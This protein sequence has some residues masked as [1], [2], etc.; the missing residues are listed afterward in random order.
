MYI[1]ILSISASSLW[2]KLASSG[3][4]LRSYCQPD[5]WWSLAHSVS[6]VQDCPAAVRSTNLCVST[7]DFGYG[8]I[9]CPRSEG[10]T[11]VQY[12]KYAKYAVENL[13]VYRCLQ[14]PL[15]IS[16]VPNCFVKLG[17]IDHSVIPSMSH[18]SSGAFPS[19]WFNATD[20]C[21]AHSH[22]MCLFLSFFSPTHTSKQR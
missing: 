10:M 18:T 12:A 14:R 3:F 5:N 9:V 4:F 8:S 6:L 16:T 21:A 2:K 15:I 7:K 1:C 22:Q 19:L 13:V 11:Q 17:K 20:G